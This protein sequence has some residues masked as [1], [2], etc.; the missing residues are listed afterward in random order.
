M[1]YNAVTIAAQGTNYYIFKENNDYFYSEDI[2]TLESFKKSKVSKLKK[3]DLVN[4]T[5]K[6]KVLIK[7]HNR[8]IHV[9]YINEQNG[10]AIE[11][12]VI[13]I[14]SGGKLSN[15]QSSG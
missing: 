10:G 8:E 4:I 5:K 13:Q 3:E 6:L 14:K 1:G 12:R 15:F 7:K 9:N 11:T 2:D